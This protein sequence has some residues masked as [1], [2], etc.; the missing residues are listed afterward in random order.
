MKTLTSLVLSTVL[1]QL[2]QNLPVKDNG[3]RT[4]RFTVVYT[5]GQTNGEI[6]RRERVVADYTR[7]LPQDRA[8]WHNVS[9]ATAPGADG[10]F[11]MPDAQQYMEGFS[12]VNALDSKAFQPEFFKNFPP[13]AMQERNM[14]WDT[15]M[16]ELFGQTQF[17]HLELNKPLHLAG[18]SGVINLAGSGKFENKNIELT[19]M[20]MSQRNGQECA[21]IGYRAFFNPLEID[22]PGIKMKGR[23]NYWGEIWVSLATKQIEYGTLYEDVLGELQLPQQDKPMVVNVVRSGAFEVK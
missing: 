10:P 21:L 1:W 19:W 18:A 13:N 8:E 12:Y 7:G 2:P 11:G 14:V 9:I 5:F 6:V 17:E 4:Y 15:Q 3:P 23:S 22:S 16:L 20:G